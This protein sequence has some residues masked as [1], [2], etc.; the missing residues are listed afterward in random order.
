MGPCVVQGLGCALGLVGRHWA[1]PP[2]T[3][4][5]KPEQF[6]LPATIGIMGVSN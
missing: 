3:P 6:L 2:Y 1:L 4:N 5:P